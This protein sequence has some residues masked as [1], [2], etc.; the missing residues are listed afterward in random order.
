MISQKAE[1]HF[2]ELVRDQF[3]NYLTQKV[4]EVCGADLFERLLTLLL[5]QIQ[6]LAHDVHG[7]RAVQKLVEQAVARGKVEKLLTALPG[8]L[9]EKL[10]RN[11][12]GFHVV[13]R[14]VECLPIEKVDALISRLCGTPE[15]TLALGKDQWGCCVLK[16][17]IDRSEGESREM[18]VRSIV[19]SAPDLVQD[20]FGNYV[21]QHFILLGSCQQPNTCATC[22]IDALKGRMFE[23]AQQKFSSNVLEKCLVNA[24]EKDRNKIIN[25]ILNPSCCPPSQAVHTLLFHQYG[26][27]VFQQALEYAK[28]PHFSLLVEHTKPHILETIRTSSTQSSTV[29]AKDGMPADHARRLCVRLAKKYLVLAEGLELEGGVYPWGQYGDPYENFGMDMY[30]AWEGNGGMM[31][32]PF[33]GWDPSWGALPG[34]HPPAASRGGRG[35]GK[36]KE[37]EV[38]ARSKGRQ[39]AGGNDGKSAASQATGGGGKGGSV[40]GDSNTMAVG[41]IVGYWPDYQVVYDE[42][43]PDDV[44]ASASGGRAR[45]RGKAAGAQR[46]ARAEGKTQSMA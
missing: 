14:L 28:E 8:E 45:K 19:S 37:G 44:G 25:E 9:A 46:K 38:R 6:D 33:P 27:Y 10:A 43:S 42:A 7:T 3:G 16:K 36:G 4:L 35:A 18:V 40:G 13:G 30:A 12:T 11:V 22:I 39:K 1:P 5:S 20:P 34:W 29:V 31:G 2:S 32:M 15:K 17:C 21:V 24:A 23:L 26:N 41:R